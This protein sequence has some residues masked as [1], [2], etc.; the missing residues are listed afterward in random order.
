MM[1]QFE[2]DFCVFAKLKRRPPDPDQATDRLVLACIRRALLDAFWSRAES[3]VNAHARHIKEGIELS[4][5]L[6]IEPPYVSVGPLPTF[7][8]CGYAM[9][10]LILLKSRQKGRYHSS[11]Q[12]WETVRKLRTAFGNQSRSGAE[13]NSS[14]LSMGDVE[15][16]TYSRHCSDPCASLW[17]KR[18]MIGCQR[19]MGQDWRPDRA[20]TNQ[21]LHFMLV[22]IEQRLEASKDAAD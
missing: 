4:D 20:I 18:F 11:H 17:F 2:C 6:G 9:A 21:M 8:H 3:T 19:R 7:D 13:A 16:K 12:Q 14:T 10:V 5:F 22:K 1:V 15:G